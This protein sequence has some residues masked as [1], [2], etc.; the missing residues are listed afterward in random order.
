MTVTD[1]PTPAQLRELVAR[2]E[3]LATAVDDMKARLRGA[4]DG[5]TSRVGFRLDYA[6]G[7]MRDGATAERETAADLER[8]LGRSDCDAEWG[9]CPE[10]GGTLRGSGGVTWCE[11]PGCRRVWN[12][13]RLGLPCDEPAV[14]VVRDGTGSEMR[15][16]GGHIIEARRRLSGEHLY[17]PLTRSTS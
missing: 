5:P 1:Q 11:G 16:C 8:V 12:H 7:Q 3:S 9:A 10:H 15:L 17:I 14:F 2:V 4:Q 13:D 6:A